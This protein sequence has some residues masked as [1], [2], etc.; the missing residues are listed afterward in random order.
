MLGKQ[1]ANGYL[2]ASGG[3][4]RGAMM[5][6]GFEVKQKR[7]VILGPGWNQVAAQVPFEWDGKSAVS[8][9]ITL[10]FDTHQL[11]AEVGGKRLTASI[12]NTWNGLRSW[13]YGGS[14]AETVF[15][16]LQLE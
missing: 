15:A 8:I 7:L 3:D 14:N 5:R 1:S 4:A 12:P 2:V 16:K 13:G 6:V 11:V 10:D 9:S